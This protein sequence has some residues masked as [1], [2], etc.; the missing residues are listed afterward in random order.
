[1]HSLAAAEPDDEL[2]QVLRKANVIGPQFFEISTLVP[3]R[4]FNQ[5]YE[6]TGHERGARRAGVDRRSSTSSSTTG[7]QRRAARERSHRDR[8]RSCHVAR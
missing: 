4:E 6:W 5:Q 8:V 1:M 2:N 7:R 3:A